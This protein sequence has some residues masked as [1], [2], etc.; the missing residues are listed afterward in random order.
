MARRTLKDQVE[1]ISPRLPSIAHGL[2]RSSR[3]N[4]CVVGHLVVLNNSAAGKRP[5]GQAGEWDLP[6][7]DMS[8]D[9]QMETVFKPYMIWLVLILF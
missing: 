3:T 9:Y 8:R 5:D 1:M 7:Q 4:Q 2:R 6:L